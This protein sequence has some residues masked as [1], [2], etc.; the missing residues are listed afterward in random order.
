MTFHANSIFQCLVVAFCLGH[1][2]AAVGVIHFEFHV[3][4]DFVHE[5]LEL[6]VDVDHLNVVAGTIAKSGDLIKAFAELCCLSV[7]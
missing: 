4:F 2:F 1:M 7:G 6:S 5:R 3:V